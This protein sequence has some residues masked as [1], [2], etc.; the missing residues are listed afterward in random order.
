M[1]VEHSLDLL[2]GNG[3]RPS[4]GPKPTLTVPQ[5]A[6]A[7]IEIADA[8]GLDA[9]SMQRVAGELG[10]TTMSLYRYVPS[11][12]QLVDVMLDIVLGEP[13]AIDHAG[14]WRAGVQTWVRE[15]WGIYRRH[16]WLLRLPVSQAPVGPNRAAWFECALRVLSGI[17]LRED[18][19]VSLSLFVDGAT[20]ELARSTADR[21]QAS[22]SFATMLQ[23]SA[24]AERFPTLTGLLDSGVFDNADDTPDDLAPNFDFG[25]QRLLDG[26]EVYVQARREA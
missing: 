25:L 11:K 4:R 16:A 8:E 12:D 18:E 14:A 22:T 23:R 2:W 5:I 24:D 13:P 1:S 3:K 15:V 10:Y 17:G 26:I 20:R 7:A 19:M 6:R 9:V 21:R